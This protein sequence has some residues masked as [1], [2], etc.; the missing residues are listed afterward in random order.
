MARGPFS[1]RSEISLLKQLSE[2]ESAIIPDCFCFFADVG[3][4]SGQ[5][6]SQIV[7]APLLKLLKKI[8]GPV[9]SINFQAVAED[10]VRRISVQGLHDPVG[11]GFQMTLDSRAI[12]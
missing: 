4:E 1:D 8:A 11:D 9:G 2:R 12:V 10:R 5:V 7:T 3:G 6:R